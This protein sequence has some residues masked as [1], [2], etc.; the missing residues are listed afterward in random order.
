[1]TLPSIVSGHTTAVRTSNGTTLTCNVPTHSN[2]DTIYFL[3]ASDGDADSASISGTGWTDVY[4]DQ[5]LASSG[6]ADSG[7]FY[8][9]KRTASSEPST[10]TV[11]SAVSERSVIIAFAVSGDNG[12]NVTGSRNA[13]TNSTAVV[14]DLTTTQN[15]CLR[16]SAIVSI[17]VKT[18]ATLSGHTLLDTIS[19]TSATT[20]S[21]QY[22]DLPTAGTDSSTTSALGSTYWQTFSFAIAG[23]IGTNYSLSATAIT[24][25]APSV[26]SAAL[27]QNHSV[28][29][30]AIT[31]GNPSVASAALTQNSSGNNLLE[32][33]VAFWALDEASGNAVDKHTNNLTLTQHGSPGA[34]TGKVYSTAR[35]FD[36]ST[37]Y[38]SRASETLLQ[39]GD[40]D[41]LF[42]AWVKADVNTANQDILNKYSYSDGNA[43]EYL[44]YY[45]YDD[46]SPT[47]YFT[48]IVNANASTYGV[49]R[50]TNFGTMSSSTW[51]FVIAWHDA[52]NNVIGISVNNGTPNTTSYSS[53]MATSSTPFLLGAE[54]NGGVHYPWDGNLGPVM[55]WKSAPGGG[56]ILTSDQIT[57]L[58]NSG[59]GLPYES[60]DS[61][62]GVVLTLNGFSTG[63]PTLE[64]PTI[65]QKHAVVPSGITTGS[66]TVESA[67][68]SQKHSLAFSAITT[69]SPTL[70]SPTLT[71][72]LTFSLSDITSGQ[73]IVE[74]LS[75]SINVGI[76]LDGITTGNPTLDNLVYI[77]NLVATAPS[78]GP[79][80]VDNA[81]LY[82]NHNL[83][84]AGITCDQPVV[85]N[86]DVSHNY[87]FSSEDVY[88]G[89][90]ENESTAI[91]QVH[92][93]SLDDIASG[94]PVVDNLTLVEENGISAVNI[95]TGIPEIDTATLLQNHALV[96]NQIATGQPTLDAL[97][98]AQAHNITANDIT[99]GQ[100]F[101]DEIAIDGASHLIP[102]GIS[103]GAP[104]CDALTIHQAHAIIA[105]D[106]TLGAPQVQNITATLRFNLLT[107][108]VA[109]GQPILENPA[110]SQKH[111]LL[112]SGIATGQPIV[113]T[114]DFAFGLVMLPQ[115]I[116]TDTPEVGIASLAQKHAVTAQ[117]VTSG[118]PLCGTPQAGV[119]HV[120][121]LSGVT[122]GH[123]SVDSATVVVN[124][125]FAANGIVAGAPEND[126]VTVS[127]H[128]VLLATSITTGSPS[129]EEF[130]IATGN[131]ILLS[132]ILTGKP[133]LDTLNVSIKSN[134]SGNNIITGPVDIAQL[135]VSQQHILFANIIESGRPVLDNA[136]LNAGDR[137]V[138][139][140]TY[141]SPRIYRTRTVLR[142]G[143]FYTVRKYWRN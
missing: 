90:P 42:A 63:S 39:G 76:A 135:S 56:G 137:V 131:V 95:L 143:N 29:P 30:S 102:V 80:V 65:S 71:L 12:I 88:T 17:G 104:Q 116:V 100:P 75:V 74:Q 2:G 68:I 140:K 40:N 61:G 108:D 59:A 79:P 117:D 73:P 62:G 92:I 6:V 7:S 66:A 58:Y 113:D 103:S 97:A 118:A 121:A 27:S 125:G 81:V 51:Y 55:M 11:T 133:T 4:T 112:L 110:L 129:L 99:T 16:I 122:T 60:F 57:T 33:L 20:I 72:N 126:S 38:F 85:D 96:A 128:H 94:T 130:E 26:G 35:T 9:W 49:V 83:A 138:T 45:N 98:I 67:G 86:L 139:P 127:Q 53:G 50:A 28:A 132:P 46:W 25:S 106:I 54:D 141:V 124:V 93:V 101:V 19:A 136:R 84:G 31:T 8:C 142:E 82:Q 44:L 37:Q 22:K 107:A 119:T 114:L 13:G 120:L 43:C 64:S 69:G 47:P 78:T 24:T 15:D 77:L 91:L 111:A 32:N 3:W 23:V 115:N 123:P 48:F 105:N 87:L 18:V 5:V 134:L 109:T 89:P 14:T 70:D 21:V 34:S 52:V 41:I 1:M 36:G 10:Y